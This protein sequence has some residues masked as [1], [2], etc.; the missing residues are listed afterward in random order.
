MFIA[1]LLDAIITSVAFIMANSSVLLADFLKTSIELLA[2]F[3]SWMA[4]RRINR[5]DK[6]FEYG[7]GKLENM[8][9]IFVGFVMFVSFV[10][11]MVNAIRNIFH[12]GHIAGIGVWISVGAQSLY[13]V[14]NG[15]L[16]VKN[17]KLAK[18][19]SSPLMDS[20]TRLFLT[21]FIGNLFILISLALSLLLKKYSW[22][23]YIDPAAS[24]IIAFSIL[25]AILGIFSSSI[26]DLLDRT[27]E[28]ERQI[29]ILQELVGFFDDYQQVHGIRSRRSGS[30][31]YI[32]IFLEF[33]PEKTVAEVQ[34]V[35]DKLRGNLEKKIQGSS[36]TIGLTTEAVK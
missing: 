15:S 5:G 11:I 18:S 2:I 12:P 13:L 25:S 21:R 27:L 35:I 26:Y 8:L 36:V 34:K 9:S 31:V 7:L 10:I 33:S 19:S 6:S 28:E 3:L 4:M 32:E 29:L 30:K 17:K 24:M 20:Q 23:V 1:G 22:S 16:Y 14:I